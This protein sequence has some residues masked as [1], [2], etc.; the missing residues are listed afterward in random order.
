MKKPKA[1]WRSS[2]ITYESPRV[3]LLDV[4]KMCV[5]SCAEQPCGSDVKV[6]FRIG[7]TAH[8]LGS[9]DQSTIWDA[10]SPKMIMGASTEEKLDHPTQNKYQGR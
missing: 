1:N 3:N 2:S 5:S 10:A 9:R 7:K 6:P 4:V 8:W